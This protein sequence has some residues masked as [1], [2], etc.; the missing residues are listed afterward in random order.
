MQPI[1]IW[2]G[3]RRRYAPRNDGGGKQPHFRSHWHAFNGEQKMNLQQLEQ[4]MDC[5]V[6]CAPRNNEADLQTPRNDGVINQETPA[7]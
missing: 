1:K 2:H 3:L 5:D 6:A 4:Q 7:A